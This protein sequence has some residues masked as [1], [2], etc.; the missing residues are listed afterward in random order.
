MQHMHNSHYVG[1]HCNITCTAAC[2]ETTQNWS[3]A[4]E[5]LHTGIRNKRKSIHKH[6]TAKQGVDLQ[7]IDCLFAFQVNVWR[8]MF[9]A[10][11]IGVLKQL[12]HV[13]Q[14]VWKFPATTQDLS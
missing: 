9:R 14:T 7:P 1:L 8:I 5:G 11:L 6:Y 3:T 4:L 2:Y 13:S 12:G 10:V